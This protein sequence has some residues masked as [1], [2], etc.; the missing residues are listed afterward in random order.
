MK[1]P[2]GYLQG[3][4]AKAVAAADQVVLA[5]D[6]TQSAADAGQLD[7]MLEQSRENMTRAGF[8]GRI[9]TA[10]ADAG[11][12]EAGYGAASAPGDRRMEHWLRTKRGEARYRRRGQHRAGVRPGEGRPRVPPLPMAGSG[13]VR[14][15]VAARVRDPQPAQ[16]VAERPSPT[17]HPAGTSAA[18]V[19]RRAT[20]TDPAA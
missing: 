12:S 14:R 10:L 4:N 6:L 1:G 17:S 9:G 2:A 13:G 15:Q 8:S 11:W 3:Y 19:S 20:G 7:P 5:T 18:T 16:A